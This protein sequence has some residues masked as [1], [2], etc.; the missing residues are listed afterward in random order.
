MITRFM[1]WLGRQFIPWDPWNIREIR[2]E[3]HAH[4]YRQGFRQGLK[5]SKKQNEC[6]CACKVVNE[7]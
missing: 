5:A 3:A 7:K 4:G 6:K 1:Q 2:D